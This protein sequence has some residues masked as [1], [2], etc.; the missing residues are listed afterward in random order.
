MSLSKQLNI[1]T[2]SPEQALTASWLDKKALTL[3]IKRDDL[4]HPVISGNKWR[5]LVYPLA[6]AQQKQVKHIISFGGG[7]SNHLHALGY[8]CYKLGIK[9]T[10]IV[11]GDYS[12]NLSPMLNDLLAWQTHVQYVN[13]ITY[14]KRNDPSYLE[15]L[16]KAYPDSLIIPEGGSQQ[17]AL[18]GVANIVTELQH[19]Y[20]YIIAP[21]ASGGTL[22][23]LINCA[24]NFSPATQVIGIGV[25]K[26]QGYLEELVASFLPNG[27]TYS[28]WKI[29]HDY[30]FG[31]YGKSTPELNQFC[32]DFLAHFHIPIEP[33]YSGKLCYGIKDLANR[34][35]FPKNSKILALHTGGL[36]GA[37]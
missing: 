1:N 31:G 6:E 16:T 30:H 14:K 9:F 17:Q 21:V 25:L 4:V 15:E 32:S 2:P 28:N 13:R 37:R 36:Q 26:G 12:S 5:K 10:A 18:K 35:Y 33:V 22:A 7:F 11:R 19:Q 34:D 29:I 27:Q 24:A 3:T 8:C 23:G 20:D